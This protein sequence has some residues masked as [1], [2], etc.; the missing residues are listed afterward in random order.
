MLTSSFIYPVHLPSC[1]EYDNQDTQRYPCNV[2]MRDF[3]PSK[4]P[5]RR[6]MATIP[7]PP[8]SSEFLRLLNDLQLRHFEPNSG[9]ISS[10]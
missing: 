10:P 9:M 7:L 5:G 6:S 2:R 8:D 4:K 1:E 3:R